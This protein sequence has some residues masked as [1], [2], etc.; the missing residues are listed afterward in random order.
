MVKRPGV[1]QSKET[2]LQLFYSGGTFAGETVA[3]WRLEFT[4]S[5]FSTGAVSFTPIWGR[6]KKGLLIDQLESR[7]RQQVEKKYGKSRKKETND[8]REYSWKITDNLRPGTPK[9]IRL[10]HGWTGTRLLELV[11]SDAPP[12]PVDPKAKDDI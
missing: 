8:Y 7:I 1:L 12:A 6:D 11:Y 2:P 5:K 3:G 10:F 4:D 9:T